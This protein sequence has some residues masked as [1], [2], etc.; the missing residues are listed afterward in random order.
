MNFSHLLLVVLNSPRDNDPEKK[1]STIQV[2]DECCKRD[3]LW[4][5]VD[6]DDR[7]ILKT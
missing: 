3:L 4:E 1:A 6:M 7:E 2:N 5:S